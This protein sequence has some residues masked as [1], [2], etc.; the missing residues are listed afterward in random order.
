MSTLLASNQ[1]F[2]KFSLRFY[3][4]ILMSHIW[5]LPNHVPA[6]TRECQNAPKFLSFTN[7][8]M[9]DSIYL[10]DE[11]LAKLH[12]IH[13]NEVRLLTPHSP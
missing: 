10:L 8:M 12:K 6:F 11:S 13:E 7:M 1:F 9:N 2:E 4:G 5:K 3:C